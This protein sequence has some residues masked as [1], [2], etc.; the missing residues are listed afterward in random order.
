MLQRFFGFSTV[1]TVNEFCNPMGNHL[2]EAW[3]TQ[4][5]SQIGGT[6]GEPKRKSFDL[7][8]AS[9]HDDTACVRIL[10]ES[11]IMLWRHR[12]MGTITAGPSVMARPETLIHGKIYMNAWI[13]EMM[14]CIIARSKMIYHF[15]DVICFEVW[16]VAHVSIC[17]RP[18]L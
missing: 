16:R 13:F 2:R 12:L 9:A 17:N 18:A 8:G 4:A 10:T 7:A 6:I 5:N 15:R 1:E 3:S 14:S 11:G